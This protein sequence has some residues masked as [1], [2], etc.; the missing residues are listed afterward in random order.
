MMQ[1]PIA[2]VLLGVYLGLLA[3]LFP[4]LIAF[5]IGF[6]F[7]YFTNV[8]VPALG[9]VVVSGA[10]AG[11][12]GGLMGFIDPQMADSWTG[13]TATAV[14]LMASLWAH[15]QGD[16]LAVATPRGL[17]L[18]RLRESRLSSD[19]IE[20]ID[21]LGQVHIRPIGDIQ[22][23]EG[24][25]PLSADLRERLTAGSWKFPADLP[26]SELEAKLEA[27]LLADYELVDVRVTIDK[28]GRAE[29]AAAPESAGLS[30]RVPTGKRAVTVKTLLPTGLARGDVVSIEL[31]TGTV[32]GPVVSARTERPRPEPSIE[33]DEP[34]RFDD[35]EPVESR[36]PAT[37]T[38]EGGLGQVT[39]VVSPAEAREVLR[40]AFA[41]IVVHPRGTYREYETIALLTDAGAK[42]RKYSLGADSDL[43]GQTIGGAQIRDTYGV[44]V[45]AIRRPTERIVA[46]SGRTELHG[47]D[48][49][50]VV[51]TSDQLAAFEEVIA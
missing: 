18:R 41:P 2:Q 27:R 14:I 39:I 11:V 51:G 46:P 50:I 23:L 5:A 22:H 49:L 42:F 37:A 7:K 32:T 4:A 16:K 26:R 29:I 48:D 9:V 15:S 25:P 33:P 47:G 20:R 21:T 13:I 10:L 6:G 31:S 3:A 38:T 44:A 35:T 8:T 28:A 1:V 43:V 24:Y 30:R 12:S 40:T 19:L 36:P 34:A 17:T 45:L